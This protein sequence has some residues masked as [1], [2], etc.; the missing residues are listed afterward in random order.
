[1]AYQPSEQVIRLL[2]LLNP[3]DSTLEQFWAP[4]LDSLEDLI[5]F[6]KIVIEFLKKK[7]IQIYRILKYK[8]F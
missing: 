5:E 1:M 3:F 7:H 2:R 6:T 4:H 8:L